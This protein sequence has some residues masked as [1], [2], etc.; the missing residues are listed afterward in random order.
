M[1]GPASEPRSPDDV[2]THP[3]S[4]SADE[5][6]R[7]VWVPAAGDWI[8]G[9]YLLGAS[10]GQGALGLVFRARDVSLR[11]EVA[12]KLLRPEWAHDPSMVCRLRDEAQAMASVLHARLPIVFSLG[13]HRG[14]PFVVLELIEG[15][16]VLER[17]R[18]E[19]SLAPLEVSHVVSAIAEGL[20]AL[21]A[22]GLEHGDV[23]PANVIVDPRGGVRLIDAGRETVDAS[24]F[25]GTPAYAAPERLV[26]ATDRRGIDV[27][28]D[29]YSL[30]A[31]A[32]ELL[33]GSLPSS[34]QGD[35]RRQSVASVPRASERQP[36]LSLAIDDALATGLARRPRERPASAGAFAQRLA[37]AA[38]AGGP[39]AVSASSPTLHPTDTVVRARARRV[40]IVDGD[41]PAARDLARAIVRSF[42]KITV[43]IVP[44]CVAASD[45]TRAA[46]LLDAVIIATSV[47][48]E[49]TLGLVR[50]LG[51]G[52]EGT[53][54]VVI[55]ISRAGRPE[56]WAATHALRAALDALGVARFYVAPV[57]VDDVVTTLRRAWLH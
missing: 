21:H 11:R 57:A 35:S 39:S 56:D 19:G 20:D 54:P 4:A 30:A 42:R 52:A 33:T 40:L 45:P 31:T 12:L 14:L 38:R 9:T 41:V 34:Q 51:A 50:A 23:K 46:T 1:T 53:R 22:A 3:S 44:D 47:G 48:A 32:F 5:R 15:Q 24:G 18:A 29:V 13:V 43:E 17:L 8:A 16:S 28:S 2:P 7:S 26:R 55:A 49:P 37:D 10:L 27:A 36:G 6:D 25:E